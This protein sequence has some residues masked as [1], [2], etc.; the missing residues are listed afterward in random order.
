MGLPDWA[1]LAALVELSVGAAGADVEP[2]P[3][4]AGVG[5]AGVGAAG[6]EPSVGA[7]G[8]AGE[9]PELLAGALGVRVTPPVPRVGIGSGAGVGLAA[10]V[11]A[12]FVA[13]VVVGTG[14]VAG[15]GIGAV[16]IGAGA[17]VGTPMEGWPMGPTGLGIGLGSGRLCARVP[18]GARLA[19]ED[20]VFAGRKPPRP[21]S[22]TTL[23]W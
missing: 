22:D 14:F 16:G 18:L 4:A 6:V 3:G 19:P 1:G 8:A 9:E 15:V 10:D 11:G 5:A 21:A 17:V 20:A 13:G 2:S 7:A 12:G 23:G